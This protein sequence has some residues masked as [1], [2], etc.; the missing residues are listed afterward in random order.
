MHQQPG[1]A[2]QR[3]GVA[4]DVHNARWRLPRRPRARC[5]PRA[6]RARRL[7]GVGQGLDQRQRAFARWVD[8][9][10][11]RHAVGHQLLRRHREQV[12]RHKRGRSQP[13]AAL[14]VVRPVV[15][16]ALHQRLAA[17]HPQHRTGLRGQRQREVAQATKP[18]DHA[19]VAAHLQQPQR[20]RHQHA[21][22]VRVDLGEIGGPVGHVDAEL[23]QRVGQ[24]WRAVVRI[25][26]VHAVGSGGLQ[27]PLDGRLGM[28]GGKGAQ[29]VP[30]VLVQRLQ[31]AQHQRGDT[32]AAGQLD[33]RTALTGVQPHDQRAQGLQ[34]RADRRRQHGAGV[35]VGHVAAFALVETH[36]HRA[37]AWH[38]AHRQPGTPAVAPRRPGD[39]RQHPL[40]SHLA[41]ALQV[42]FQR[43][44][45][46]RHLRAG[47]DVLHFA[48]AARARMQ[49]EVGAARRHPQRRG[50]VDRDGLGG[51][52]LWFAP[53]HTHL[54][55]LAGQGAFDKHHLAL[56]TAP[57]AV[58]FQ[59]D[60]VDRHRLGRHTRG[61]HRRHGLAEGG[62]CHPLHVVVVL[63]QRLGSRLRGSTGLP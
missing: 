25:E 47:V 1:V 14:L 48:A 27:P 34:Q 42:V 16:R 57:H 4:T 52:P 51:F 20:A 35:H 62:R 63:H 50:A 24:R 5:G 8:Q 41:Q 10:A 56:G 21:V 17:L 55:P 11:L 31:V 60:G 32:F 61:A 29:Q 49:A 37:F 19:L 43:T 53:R 18:V 40:R 38:V 58:R 33:L 6:A 46:D 3:G 22:D 23:R 26:P 39:G 9:P 28:G 30:V 45:L 2:R 44:L 54:G 36:E 12:A 59:V 13:T 15:T 7:H